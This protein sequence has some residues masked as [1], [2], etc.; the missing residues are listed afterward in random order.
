VNE[1][2]ENKPKIR[3]ILQWVYNKKVAYEESL[4][5]YEEKRK[6]LMRE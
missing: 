2:D 6:N 3:V 1:D 5:I 4:A